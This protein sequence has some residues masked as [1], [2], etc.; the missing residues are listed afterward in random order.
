VLA[1][2]GRVLALRLDRLPSPCTVFAHGYYKTNYPAVS[3]IGPDGR[4]ARA[5]ANRLV[6]W[7]KRADGGRW[8]PSLWPDTDCH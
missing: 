6:T 3:R 5:F 8:I 1:S 4:S 2:K 7:F